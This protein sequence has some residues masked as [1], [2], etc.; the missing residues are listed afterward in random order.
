[1]VEAEEV[2]DRGL[3]VVDVDL[4]FDDAETEVIGLAVVEARLYAAAGKPQEGTITLSASHRGNQV[5]IRIAD[6]GRGIDPARLKQKARE[7]EIASDAELIV[8]MT[9]AHRDAVLEIAPGKLR[10]T[11]TLCEAS[12]LISEKNARAIADLATLRP[13]L[14]NSELMD[15]PD[16]IG[17]GAEVFAEVGAQIAA[18]MPPIVE[19]FQGSY[20][21][22]KD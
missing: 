2:H 21:A 19:L 1:M 7:K 18:L 9:R 22:A 17:R 16:P 10:R 12:R 6:D 11:F 20:G 13:H 14:E 3:Q 4:V 5:V 8:T 15:V